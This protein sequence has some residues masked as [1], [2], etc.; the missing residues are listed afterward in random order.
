VDKGQAAGIGRQASRPQRHSLPD[1]RLAAILDTLLSG[2]IL[3]P[4]V[5]AK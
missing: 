1:T 3:L 4:F 2:S 5:K